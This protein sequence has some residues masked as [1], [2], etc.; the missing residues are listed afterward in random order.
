M[1]K[2]NEYH[3]KGLGMGVAPHQHQL[4]ANLIMFGLMK[5]VPKHLRLNFLPDSTVKE[6]LKEGEKRIRPDIS[7][8]KGACYTKGDCNHS[9]L[10]FVVEVVGVNGVGYSTRRI[11]ELFQREK[12]MQEAF[13]YNYEEKRWTRFL[14]ENGKVDDKEEAYSVTFGFSMSSIEGLE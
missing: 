13:L 9:D 14:R 5:R 4:C 2:G 1:K 3:R 12:T 10:L 7:Y 8:Y 6:D 11:K